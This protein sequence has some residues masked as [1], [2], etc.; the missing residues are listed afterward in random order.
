MRPRR[1][2]PAS[3]VNNPLP[4]QLLAD[5]VLALHVAIVLFVVGG[6]VLVVIGNLR[7]WPWAN[8]LWFRLAHLAAIA[9]VAAQAWLGIECPLTTLEMWLRRKAQAATYEGSFVEHWLQALLYWQAPSWVFTLAY[10]AFAMAVAAAWWF[11]P[12]VS[13]KHRTAAGGRKTEGAHPDH[14][15]HATGATHADSHDP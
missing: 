3:E 5:A 12:P 7:N 15:H 6:L 9:F 10:T 11:Y 2:H 1:S 14:W 13:G 4:F 8:A